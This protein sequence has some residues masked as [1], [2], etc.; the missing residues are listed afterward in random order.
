MAHKKTKTA[1]ENKNSRQVKDAA[2]KSFSLQKKI[3]Q[4]GPELPSA[5]SIFKGSIGLIKRNYK[6]F[7]G[8]AGWYALIN[9]VFVQGLNPGADLGDVK[10]TL[11]DIISGNWSQLSTGA[12]SFA[13]LISASGGS[14]D[15]TSS[16]YQL[17]WMIVVS[18]ALIWTI[19]QRYADKVVRIRDG[20]YQGMY[21]FIPF[22]LVLMVIGLQSI[23]MI[24]G[25]TLLTIVMSNGIATTGVEVFIWCVLCFS[26]VVLSLYMICSSIFALYIVG[27]Q[28]STPM[29]ALRSARQLS[30]NRRWL[31]LRKL[32]FL[33][34]ILLVLW[35]IIMIPL[36]LLIPAVAVWIFFLIMA[37]NVVVAH[38]YYYALYRSLL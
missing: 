9:F 3:T 34:F 6:L 30:A 27:L 33:P 16:S 20:F 18:L 2:Y 37:V 35:G 25:G 10:T 31:V 24:V 17:V 38:S 15:S 32:L 11:A 22:I 1:P 29:T 7:L 14:P 36:I 12:A 21:P 4:T 28:D 19:R 23:P 8:I 13:Y 5:W 26:L